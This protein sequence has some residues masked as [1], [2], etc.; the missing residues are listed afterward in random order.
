MCQRKQKI[1]C[2]KTQC[3]A[4]RPVWGGPCSSCRQSHLDVTSKQ[5]KTRPAGGLLDCSGSAADSQGKIKVVA[6]SSGTRSDLTLGLYPEISVSIGNSCK[7]NGTKDC[8]QTEALC[9]AKQKPCVCVFVF[10]TGSQVAQAGL[11]F[12]KYPE[13]VYPELLILLPLNK[14]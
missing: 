3:W 6:V 9:V 5:M 12:D 13:G 4:S 1:F 10:D 2:K 7:L 14:S 8:Y 11:T